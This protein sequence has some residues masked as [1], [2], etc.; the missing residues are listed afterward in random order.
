VADVAALRD[1][2][3]WW[4]ERDLAQQPV[5][6]ELRQRMRDSVAPEDGASL[7]DAL[8][9]LVGLPDEHA[10]VRRAGFSPDGLRRLR[11]AGELFARLR[12]RPR[13]GLAELA[14]VVIQELGLDIEVMANDMRPAGMR[15]FEPFFEAIAGFEQLSFGSSLGAFLGWLRQAAE[16]DRLSG[17]IDAEPLRGGVQLLTIH[18]AKGLEWDFVAVPRLVAGELPADPGM[19]ETWL[20]FGKLPYE[21]R[22]DRAQ[23]PDFGWRGA[24]DRRD[25]AARKAAYDGPAGAERDR[26]VEEARRLAYVAVTRARQALL[27]SGSWWAS[28]AGSRSPSVFLQDIAAAEVI[29]PLPTEPP[30][31]SRVEVPPFERPWPR[32]PLGRRRRRVE[33]AARLVAAAD[34]AAA[35][36]WADEIGLLLAEREG[37]EAGAMAVP[38][39]IPASRFHEYLRDPE[40]V[41]AE[42]RRPMPQRPF[43][44]TRRGTEFHSW[45]ERLF[46]PDGLSDGLELQEDSGADALEVQDADALAALKQR[47]LATDWPS[48]TPIEV[49]CEIDVPFGGRIVICRIDAVFPGRD[50]PTRFEIV[51]WKTGK[52]PDGDELTRKQLQLALYR[53]AY[54]KREGIP[55]ERIDASFYYVEHDVEIPATALAS[56][57]ELLARWRAAFGE[58]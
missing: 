47:F 19:K 20:Q 57:D 38:V 33:E 44:A 6:A 7:V 31:G 24:T 45:A 15:V 25:L 48:R 49:E 17:P 36:R 51:D 27:L 28:Q 37:G 30:G 32:D 58:G 18:G 50:D 26:Q 40:A 23:L 5:A 10:A 56:E 8:D 39:R 16:R 11:D 43:R 4:A 1:L 41:L 3:S 2:A 14:T 13:F 29:A 35:G 55:P 21:F 34:P 12:R 9:L 53:M 42:L 22:G 52:V 54:A 46:S